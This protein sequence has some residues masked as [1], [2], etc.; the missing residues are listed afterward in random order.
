[1]LSNLLNFH[2]NSLSQKPQ[3]LIYAASPTE[4]SHQQ[5]HLFKFIHQ[6]S[7]LE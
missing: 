2:Q 5:L 6:E 7:T 3:D 1:M 4:T